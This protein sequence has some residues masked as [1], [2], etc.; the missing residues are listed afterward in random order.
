MLP[1]DM[2][3]D[4]DV[5][6]SV[7]GGSSAERPCRD[8]EAIAGFVLWGLNCLTRCWDNIVRKAQCGNARC[9]ST[10]NLLFSFTARKN[11]AIEFSYKSLATTLSQNRALA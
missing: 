6:R 8:S 9:A 10:C 3:N 7:E 5:G 4:A 11:I 2:C 1:V